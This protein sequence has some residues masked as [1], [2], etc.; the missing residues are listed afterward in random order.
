MEKKKAAKEKERLA[1]VAAAAARKEAYN[2][3]LAMLGPA[4]AFSRC[5]PLWP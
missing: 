5:R 4:G 1:K 3:V 2:A